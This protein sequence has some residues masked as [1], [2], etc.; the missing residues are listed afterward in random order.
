MNAE[1]RLQRDALA[2][3]WAGAQPEAFEKLAENVVYLGDDV[4][5][6]RE[7]IKPVLTQPYLRKA[8][9]EVCE[10]KLQGVAANRKEAARA[11]VRTMAEAMQ[12]TPP[13][14][15]HGLLTATFFR[16]LAEVCI[17]LQTELEA[18][19]AESEKAQRQADS[20]REKA[21]REAERETSAKA[22]RVDEGKARE[23]KEDVGPEKIV[24]EEIGT[25]GA[26]K[27]SVGF[28]G[29]VHHA[30]DGSTNPIHV[31]TWKSIA[32]GQ[33]EKMMNATMQAGHG[34]VDVARIV[35]VMGEDVLYTFMARVAV[36]YILAKAGLDTKACD[37]DAVVRAAKGEGK[38]A[39]NPFEIFKST[40]VKQP[41][42]TSTRD[43]P[44]KGNEPSVPGKD[45]KGNPMLFPP[46]W[47]A[48]CGASTH[49]S[50]ACQ[51]KFATRHSITCH[52]CGQTGHMKWICPTL[53]SN[54]K[55][56]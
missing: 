35:G 13:N 31:T 6:W 47:C 37:V 18:K 38:K 30:R 15:Q 28:C 55:G 49:V 33:E 20:E 21:Q 16:E 11:E 54:G 4:A 48:N 53:G 40:P 41:I 39:A 14:V 51:T 50:S 29:D 9:L 5:E 8:V 17:R 3:G 42:I 32:K 36:T 1:Q 19:A 52:D 7:A 45:A 46:I 26:M 24:H 25:M 10:G 44:I 43:T 23:S 22:A 56:K 12:M 27:L 2:A 34:E